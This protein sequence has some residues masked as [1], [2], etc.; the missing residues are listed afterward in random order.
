MKREVL[1]E[2]RNEDG[3]YTRVEKITQVPEDGFVSNRN[4]EGV[5][6]FFTTTMCV[7]LEG[8]DSKDIEQR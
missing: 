7:C 1:K 5:G 6:D 4:I 3:S 2:Q 8:E